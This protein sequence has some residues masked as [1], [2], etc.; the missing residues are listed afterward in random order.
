MEE[1]DVGSNTTVA[2]AEPTHSATIVDPSTY[3]LTD[4]HYENQIIVNQVVSMLSAMG[5][6]YIFLSMVVTAHRQKKRIERTFDKLLL[7][8]C[9]SDFISSVSLFFGAW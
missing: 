8:L 9:V 6:A 1:N 5:S 3:L 2:V 4:N 7:C